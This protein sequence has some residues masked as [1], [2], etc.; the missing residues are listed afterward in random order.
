MPYEVWWE[1]RIAY[2]R[3]LESTDSYVSFVASSSALSDLA[4]PVD[5]NLKHWESYVPSL[6]G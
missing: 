6:V 1:E 5:I 4:S 2:S 3:P